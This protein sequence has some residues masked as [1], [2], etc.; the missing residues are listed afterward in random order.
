M[1]FFFRYYDRIVYTSDSLRSRLI[2]FHDSL[3]PGRSGYTVLRPQDLARHV[4][5]Y[6]GLPPGFFHTGGLLFYRAPENTG[7][8]TLAREAV[9]FTRYFRAHNLEKSIREHNALRGTTVAAG[10]T[11]IIPN[12]LPSLIPDPR[13]TSKAPVIFT[14]GLYFSG[15]TAGSEK[16]LLTLERFIPLGINALVFDARDV[17]GIVNYRSNVPAVLELDTHDKHPIDDIDKLIRWLKE[18]RVY[19]I[20]RVAVF[21]DDL[22]YKRRPMWAIRSKRTGGRWGEGGEHWCDPTNRGVQDYAI[23]LAVELADKG[24]DEVQFDYIRFP[25]TGDLGDAVYAYDFGRMSREQT[26]AR[27]L[28]RAHAELSKRNTRLSIDIFGV[29]AWGKEVDIDATGQRIQ[30]LAPHCDVISPMLYPSH[31]NDEFDGYAN[32][33]D[34]PYYFI[35][36]GCKKVGAL[37]GRTAI[38]PWLQAFRWRVSNYGPGYIREQV[39]ASDDSGA[40]G[41]LF[42]NAGNS[43]EEVYDAWRP[44]KPRQQETVKKRKGERKGDTQ[45]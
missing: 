5:A 13:R 41:Y 44:Q 18:R 22:L 16:G 33:G 10:D 17:T 29:V 6:R 9:S 19:T 2:E 8:G 36:N 26:I 40:N 30:L 27:F 12:P 45:G 31:F 32:P 43:Y 42:W 3:T 25:T 14:R 11:I 39:K 20:A 24:V 35:F 23:A 28:E 15:G 4:R 7:T 38:R 21:R 1:F 37:A 34:N